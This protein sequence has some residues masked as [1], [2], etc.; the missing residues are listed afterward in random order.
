MND[1]TFSLVNAVGSTVT[2]DGAKAILPK[3]CSTVMFSTND[4]PGDFQ[5]AITVNDG[6]EF[7][8]NATCNTPGAIFAATIPYNNLGNGMTEQLTVTITGA[9]N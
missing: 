3:D 6:E 8:V 7:I 9:R 5:Q 4:T 1:I 2:L